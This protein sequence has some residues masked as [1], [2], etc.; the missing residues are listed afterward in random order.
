MVQMTVMSIRQTLIYYLFDIHIWHR[1]T[2]LRVFFK[3]D[4]PPYTTVS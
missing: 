3:R 2:L 4:N 1:I